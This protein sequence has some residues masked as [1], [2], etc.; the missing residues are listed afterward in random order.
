MSLTET[1]FTVLVWSCI[2]LG[3]LGCGTILVAIAYEAVRAVKRAGR[4]A[5]EQERT[6]R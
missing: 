4:G 2:V 5:S 6:A 3:W 1:A